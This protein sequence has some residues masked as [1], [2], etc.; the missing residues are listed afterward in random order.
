MINVS[1]IKSFSGSFTVP[2]SKPETQRAILS[3]S[4]A[5]G[6]SRVNNDLRCFET[7]L[8]KDAVKQFG[9]TIEEHNG[10]LKIHGVSN[11]INFIDP[12]INCAGSALVFRVFLALSC[13]ASKSIKLNAD[14]TLSKRVM[15]PLFHSLMSLGAEFKFINEDFKAPCVV[16]PSNLHGGTCYLPCNI[17]S[18]YITALLYLS[19][20]LPN[21]L[22]IKLDGIPYSASYIEQTLESFTSAGINFKHNDELSQYDIVPSSFQAFNQ[23]ISGDF[24][25]SSYLLACAILF[26]GKITLKNISK[27]S[28][29]GEIIILELLDYLDISY[30]YDDTRCELIIM[31]NKDR[32]V[33]DIE[34]NVKNGP[35]IT[36][37]L[38]VI[39]A[40]IEG[41]FIVRGAK[42]CQYHK[43][44]RIAVIVGELKK[45]G[46]N[47]KLLYDEN[48]DSDGFMI[49]GK[50]NY[51]GGAVFDSHHD[52]RILM[53][54]YVASLRAD[55][56]SQIATSNLSSVEA[57]FPEFFEVIKLANNNNKEEIVYV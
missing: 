6:T 41:T 9:A 21:P 38:A 47:I 37:T 36:P 53:S 56:P 46:V 52:H 12:E 28:L 8:M 25:S 45:L 7:K 4:L 19:P 24:T 3:A 15:K 10:F 43:C 26:P 30:Q 54:L 57:S 50:K 18:Q 44:P 51:T 31:N 13:L 55:S 11:N 16:L 17:S 14:I 23:D 22:S 42:V 35:N 20:F 49:Q 33:G 2:S 40:Y 27:R 39:G 48:N 5:S 29:Q 34:I 32:L 1:P